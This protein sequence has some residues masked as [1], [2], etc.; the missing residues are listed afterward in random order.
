MSTEIGAYPMIDLI[1]TDKS[2]WS[3]KPFD[4][5]ELIEAVLKARRCQHDAKA[6]SFHLRVRTP[7]GDMTFCTFRRGGFRR[8]DWGDGESPLFIVAADIL[9]SFSG[10]RVE[11]VLSARTHKRY[12]CVFDDI[13]NINICH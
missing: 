9:K 5:F 7:D 13:D 3:V 4:Y 12:A 10:S 6:R 8:S 2:D 11:F 1:L